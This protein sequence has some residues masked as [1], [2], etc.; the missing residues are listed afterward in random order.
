MQK[1]ISAIGLLMLAAT[2]ATGIAQAQTVAIAPTGYITA[3][4]GGTV[5][6]S[7]TVTG[8]T[9]DMSTTP[10][11]M[12]GGVVGGNTTVG[13]ITQAGLFT[14]P[15]TMPPS[16]MTV[17]GVGLAGHKGA[18]ATG[19]V[20]LLG[21]GPQ[22][23]SVS[24]NPLPAGSFTVTI[25]GSG[26]LTGAVV[27]DGNVQLSTVSITPN[28]IKAS[29]YQPPASSTTFA[30]RNPSTI[31]GNTITVPVTGAS[32]NT[33]STGGTGGT[34]GGVAGPVIAP[35]SATLALGATQQ[36]TAPGATS[37]LAVAGTVT[38]A[39]LYTA[40]AV[41]PSSGTDTVTAKNSSG[42][43]V[44]NITLVSNVPPTAVSV[45]TSPL[46]LGVFSTT[47]TGT[48][49]TAA[50]K[51]QLGGVALTTAYVNPTTLTIS[52]FA[53][54]A[55][56][57][58]LTVANGPIVSAPLVVPIGVQ[59]P[60]VSA[61]AARRFLEQAAFGP[62]PADAAHVQT[63]GF[64][65]WIDEQLAM[66]VIS[67]YSTVGGSQGGIPNKFLANA[68]TN[69]DQL[70]QRVSFALSQIFVISITKIIWNG[71]MIP[72]EDMLINDAFTNY[73]KILGDVTTS[74]GMGYYLDM[75]NNAKANPA[76][77]T[78]ANE[79]YAREVM[80]LFS[81]GDVLLNQDGTVQIDPSTNLPAAAYLQPNISELARV[82]TGWTYS[83]LSGK[84]SFP[85]YID[86]SGPMV[87]YTPMH[88]FGSKSLLMGYVAPANLTPQ[89]D[90]TAALDNIASHPNVA[91]FISKQLIQHL[92][93]S[94]PS[95]AYVKR[96]AQAFLQS[97]GDMPTI[98]KAILLD[99][100]A[101]ANDAGGA[102]QPTDGHLQEPALF[103]PAL[104]RAFSGT[105]T[106][107]NYYAQ[108]LAALGEDIYNPASVF[109]Y[110]SPG[111][112]VAGT[113]GLKGPEFQINNPNA[114]I[115]R[116]NL[117]AQLF[118]Q[119]SNPV[120]S[121][122]PGTTLDL[123]PFLAL[124]PTPATLVSALDLTLTHGTMPAAL[125]QIITNAVTGDQNGNLHRV[126][127][128]CYLIL[129]SNYYNVWH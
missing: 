102:D 33:G 90:L 34:G 36:F 54:P 40:P 25:T 51:A 117:V 41:M 9:G 62:T 121:N 3:G 66:P 49:F 50:S 103:L 17:I 60:M 101:R 48:G 113:G 127:T 119:Y 52:G 100:E 105:M 39:G 110:F 26:F 97:N 78:A 93:K 91:P 10:I 15:T 114:A 12:A 14:A 63:I 89:Q 123:T 72:Y 94:N 1:K 124:A 69:P 8:A 109:N 98:I 59:N 56:S 71:D 77:G 92:V 87:P 70:R 28:I 11:W 55:S 20:Y 32:G 125:N 128:A 22:I 57:A 2:L 47:L 83:H 30:V 79:N 29:G 5:Q 58:N 42:Q 31:F 99:Q 126:E 16:G 129:M 108:T 46:P 7:A 73:R 116:E 115:L 111:Y 13:T 122:G 43:S 82:F 61:S 118:S 45:S 81:M 19:Y 6:F 23:T 106:T 24:P 74:P 64:D 37:W 86:S 80:Q 96:V 27:W 76:A 85:S 120:Q 107:A 95:P 35:L 53:G 65:A 84:I 88:D 21:A 38:S 44:A 68:V 104:V 4:P 75:A 18:L 112:T 67:D